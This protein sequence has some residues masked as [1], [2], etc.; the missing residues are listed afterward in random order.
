ML[1]IPA[2]MSAL[3]SIASIRHFPRD[4][5]VGNWWLL[6][7]RGSAACARSG[8]GEIAGADFVK[9]SPPIDPSG[10]TA[11]VGL[12]TIICSKNR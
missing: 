5:H 9:V 1:T 8:R 11:W 6:D 7:A 10:G 2:H 12:S 4:R 3:I